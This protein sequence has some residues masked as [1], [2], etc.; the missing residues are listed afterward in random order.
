Y[1]NISSKNVLFVFAGAFNGEDN[2]N[3]DRLREIGL[4]TE[5]LGRVG[6]VYNTKPLTLDE[7]FLIIENSILLQKYLALFESV[8]PDD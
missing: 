3:V 1:N 4:K 7:Y 5:F 6:L 8:N 2:L